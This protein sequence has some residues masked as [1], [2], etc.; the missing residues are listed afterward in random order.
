MK[1]GND[2][3]PLNLE[4]AMI[5]TR[6]TSFVSVGDVCYRFPTRDFIGLHTLILLVILLVGTV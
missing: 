1:P 2:R 6:P 3:R 4:D 5:E